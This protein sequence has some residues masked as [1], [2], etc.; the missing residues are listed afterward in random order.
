MDKKRSTIT[1]FKMSEQEMDS[2]TEITNLFQFYDDLEA[3]ALETAH[4]NDVCFDDLYVYT[5]SDI[6]VRSLLD[7]VTKSEKL[8]PLFLSK[9]HESI[10]P[11][12]LKFILL[13]KKQ[14]YHNT[15]KEVIALRELNHSYGND[16]W[17]WTTD[18]FE[19][20]TEYI[21][22]DLEDYTVADIQ[23]ATL[24]ILCNYW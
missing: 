6:V 5:P 19:D 16:I 12:V 21:G 17:Q 2:L 20:T 4:E 8:L 9:I 24:Q 18:A 1:K 14:L 7:Y 15:R 13:T 23:T 10:K 3:V 11:S 22:S